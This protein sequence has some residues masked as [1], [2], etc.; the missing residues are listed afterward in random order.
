MQQQATTLN[1]TNP[2]N[3]ANA[4]N[5]G[6]FRSEAS[7]QVVQALCR[8]DSE[9]KKAVSALM[10]D[11]PV[12]P[13]DELVYPTDVRLPDGR[14]PE[15]VLFG[16]RMIGPVPRKDL[17][18]AKPAEGAEAT[19]TEA[20]KPVVVP[21]PKAN[22]VE[23]RRE[24]ESLLANLTGKTNA[25]PKD[26]LNK[27]HQEIYEILRF[28]QELMGDKCRGLSREQ[29]NTLKAEGVA[30]VLMASEVR[31]TYAEALDMTYM[32]GDLDKLKQLKADIETKYPV[33]KK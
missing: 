26:E 13:A 16:S 9:R 20:A 7:A 22:V 11:L 8:A 33:P 25:E 29:Q 24:T 30:N 3:L 23:A 1:N 5:W 28:Q 10:D 31:K 19:Q 4:L 14:V 17:E 12:D 2:I 18:E 32:G 27:V 6:V 21:A 15:L